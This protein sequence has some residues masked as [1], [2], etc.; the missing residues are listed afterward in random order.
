SPIP[1]GAQR[2]PGRLGWTRTSARST[3][4]RSTDCSRPSPALL[5]WPTARPSPCT[6]RLRCRPLVG[7]GVLLL[8]LERRDVQR[9]PDLRDVLAHRAHAVLVVAAPA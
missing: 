2:R 4:R 8:H 7:D 6:G 3:A 1:A 9:L 5:S